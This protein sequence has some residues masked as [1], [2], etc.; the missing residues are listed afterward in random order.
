[1]SGFGRHASFVLVI[2][3]ACGTL[4]GCGGESEYK[5]PPVGGT[6]AWHDGSEPRALE[7]AAVEF[8]SNGAVVAKTELTA[9]GTFRLDKAPPPG[10]YR[11]RIVPRTEGRPS[12][13]DPRFAKFETS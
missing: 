5:P 9:D 7:G 2:A 8:E 12:G 1:M 13:L 11:V 4:A 3:V 10:T 6:V